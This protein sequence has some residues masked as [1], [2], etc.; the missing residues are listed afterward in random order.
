MP[1]G[2]A[3]TNVPFPKAIVSISN[4]TS[5]ERFVQVTPSLDVSNPLFVNLA[6]YERTTTK[7]DAPY[8]ISF[9][10]SQLPA[11]RGAVQTFVSSEKNQLSP[12]LVEIIGRP[13]PPIITIRPLA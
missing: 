7:L 3:A 12:L 13:S 9:P 2:P 4:P 11:C 10:K 1:G 6:I 5:P 8:V